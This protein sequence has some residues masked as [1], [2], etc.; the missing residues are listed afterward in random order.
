MLF[1]NKEDV[2]LALNLDYINYHNLVGKFKK[3]TFSFYDGLM[4]VNY[5]GGGSHNPDGPYIRSSKGNFGYA[6]NNIEMCKE[7]WEI[8]RLKYLEK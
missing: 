8:E 6:L 2:A 3:G 7:E 4:F 1:R 5:K